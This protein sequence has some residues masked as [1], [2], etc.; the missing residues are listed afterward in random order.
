[1]TIAPVFVS[2]SSRGTISLPAAIRRRLKLDTPGAQVEVSLRDD[3][4]IELRPYQ[5]IP[6]NQAWC[7]TRPDTR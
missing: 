2:I 3:N 1:M 4:V 6:S 7:S 5:A